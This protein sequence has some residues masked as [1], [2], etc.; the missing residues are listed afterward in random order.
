MRDSKLAFWTYQSN[1]A[2]MDNAER[3][4]HWIRELQAMSQI[5][6]THT[7]N[8]FDRERY[9]RLGEISREMFALIGDVPVEKV[10]RFF[11]P[12]EGYCTPKVDLRA[13][14]FDDDRVLLVLEKSDGKWT[15]PGGW[16][17]VNETPSEGIR[18]EVLEE[19]G[20]LVDGVELVAVTDRSAHPYTPRYPH[21]VFKMFFYG[22]P[23]GK[24]EIKHTHE[25]EDAR[26]FALSELPPLS[27]SR[28]LRQDIERVFDYHAGKRNVYTD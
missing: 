2:Q 24:T 13:G 21:H 11:V 4:I 22:H 20:Y 9:E 25:T 14:I 12:D 19:S 17:D 7:V 15:L 16:A 10:E 18:R 6:L 5:G 1:I 8:P 23:T 3:W 27:E 26:F 28:V